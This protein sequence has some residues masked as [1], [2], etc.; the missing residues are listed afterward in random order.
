[1]IEQVRE[2]DRIAT[3]DEQLALG[4]IMLS[5]IRIWMKNLLSEMPWEKASRLRVNRPSFCSSLNGD[6]AIDPYT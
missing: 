5:I 6:A 4:S 3:R 1:M 2:L